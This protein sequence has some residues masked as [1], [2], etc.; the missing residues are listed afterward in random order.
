MALL[1]RSMRAGHLRQVSV[2][3]RH[4]AMYSVTLTGWA[5]SLRYI[6]Q[7]MDMIVPFSARL[8]TNSM[9]SKSGWLLIMRI[10]PSMETMGW[11]EPPFPGKA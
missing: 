6:L 4:S 9:P 10:Q 7:V 5:R 2:S 11:M 3:R 1:W 8:S